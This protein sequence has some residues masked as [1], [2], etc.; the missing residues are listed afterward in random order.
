MA[1]RIRTRGSSVG[2]APGA[3]LLATMTLTNTSGSTIAAGTVVPMFGHPFKKGDITTGTYPVFQDAS[4]N[5]NCPY[6]YWSKRTWSDGSWKRAGF[7]FRLPN[8]IAGSSSKTINILSGGSAPA[9][10]SVAESA[11]TSRD[12]KIVL[13]G[14]DNLSGDWT[15]EVNQGFTDG[16]DVLLGDGGAG[17]I[18]RVRQGFM[19]AAADHGQLI[20]DHYVAAL[21]NGAGGVGGFRHLGRVYQPYYDVDSPAKNKR[22]FSWVV[23][24][25]STTVA[26]MTPA[27]AKTFT[28][29]GGGSSSMTMTGHGLQSSIAGR[30]STTGSLPSGLSSTTT[31]YIYP[32]DA[33]TVRFCSTANNAITG[34]SA[35]TASDTG[36]GTHTF[37][38]HTEVVHFAS[39]Y[40]ADSAGKWQFTQGGGTF[41]ADAP[42]RFEFDKTYWRSTKMVPPW[43]LTVSPTAPSS[44]TYFPNTRGNLRDS[45]GATS[46]DDTLG[47]QPQWVA[48][49]FLGQ[50][51]AAMSR[52][53]VNALGVG[54]IPLGFKSSS[55]GTIPVITATSGTPYTG[56]GTA[57]SSLRWSQGNSAGFTAPTGD[58]AGI[59]TG[60]GSGDH[61]CGPVYYAALATGEP[62]YDD[63]M[64]EVA[65][66][67]TLCRYTGAETSPGPR[68]DTTVTGQPYYGLCIG[69]HSGSAARDDA[70]SLRELGCA[71]AIIPDSPWEKAALYNYIT[72]MFTQNMDFIAALNADKDSFWNTNGIYFFQSSYANASPWQHSY[73]YA[74]YAMLDGM[75]DGACATQLAHFMKFPAA[76]HSDIGIFHLTGYRAL[77]W[78]ADNTLVDNMNQI[79]YTPGGGW[80]A[81]VNTGTDLFTASI[82]A[83]PQTVS[84]DDRFAFSL[85]AP[86]GATRYQQYYVKNVTDPGS[87]SD[88]TFNLSAT[89]GGATLDVSSASGGEDGMRMAVVPSGAYGL[90]YPTGN[91]YC[92][93]L[94]AALRMAEARGVTTASTARGV[95]DGYVANLTLY[96][97]ADAPMWAMDTSY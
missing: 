58:V 7:M 76:V 27:S 75:L 96:D 13:T 29:A 47:I 60:T 55:T 95:L 10:S 85:A 74:T 20:C 1:L 57:S 81:T 68:N 91:S 51:E 59:Y 25:G 30:L 43:D 65:N 3:G 18:W 9:A 49:H 63:L 31:Y 26:T 50:S 17:K 80:N 40:S 71:A 87:T 84:N 12:L 78:K 23:K 37:T 93:M 62:Q 82:S 66:Y 14:I 64:V 92:L 44:V 33:N 42:I 83:K 88:K 86:T 36:S 45:W 79:V 73:L 46:Q 56:M 61:W 97:P 19:Q 16:D 48:Q 32:V 94:C 54:N 6:T 2:L 72:E 24:D 5:A 15:S 39:V 52:V 67:L 41:T 28:A 21:E 11:L 69:E 89:S 35:A 53:R 4:D 90:D 34:A 22:D 70:W 38:P 8:S 77:M